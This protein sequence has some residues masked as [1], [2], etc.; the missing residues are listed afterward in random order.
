MKNKRYIDMAGKEVIITMIISII[1]F[2]LMLL[3]TIN[4]WI[5]TFNGNRVLVGICIVTSALLL[6]ASALFTL[7]TVEIFVI[8]L[9]TKAVY[10]HKLKKACKILDNKLTDEY[11][12]VKLYDMTDLK[13]MINNA[14]SSA[15]VISQAKMS[16]GKV[17]IKM[18]INIET[19]MFVDE[20]TDHFDICN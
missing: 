9:I 5:P 14:I 19:E 4:N 6:I 16:N 17:A 13:Y 11:S 3:I 15:D 8:G 12:Y 10:N 7:T 1:V 2:G 18:Q 20:F